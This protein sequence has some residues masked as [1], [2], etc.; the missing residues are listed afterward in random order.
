MNTEGA[1]LSVFLALVGIGLGWAISRKYGTRPHN[2]VVESRYLPLINKLANLSDGLEIVWQGVAVSRPGLMVVQWVNVGPGDIRPSA[3]EGGWAVLTV[4]GLTP[5]A[6]L[7]QRIQSTQFTTALQGADDAASAALSI[8]IAP[9]LLRVG[10]RHSILVLVDGEPGEPQLDARIADTRVHYGRPGQA[11]REISTL[12]F[13]IGLL[14]G[15]STLAIVLELLDGS[16]RSVRIFPFLYEWPMTLIIPTLFVV[17]SLV[18]VIYYRRGRIPA[19]SLRDQ[20]AE[21]VPYRVAAW[22]GLV[23]IPKTDDPFDGLE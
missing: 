18:L 17:Y 8:E 3:F 15:I 19:L 21:S 5:V 23:K 7:R 12:P 13:F 1:I 14:L 22:L 10:E 20:G 2:L 4:A 6:P 11:R 9:T 16:L